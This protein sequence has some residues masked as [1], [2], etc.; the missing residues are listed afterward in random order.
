MTWFTYLTGLIVFAIGAVAKFVLNLA[1]W[2]ALL[3]LVIGLGYVTLAEGMRSMKK[4]KRAFLFLA[5]LWSI[6]VLVTMIP[7]AKEGYALWTNDPARLNRPAVRLELITEHVGVLVLSAF[8]FVV[9][10]VALYRKPA[11]T[12]P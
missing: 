9:A 7:M 12:I 2:Q 4:Q 5:V 3:P 10:V 8:Y 6:V 1:E 11:E